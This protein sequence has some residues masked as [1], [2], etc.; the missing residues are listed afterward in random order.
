[1]TMGQGAV[2]SSLS[3]QKLNTQSSCEAELAG[4]DDMATKI[5]WKKFFLKEQGYWIHQNVLYQDNKSK[6]LL[7][8]NG[9]QSAGKQ[10]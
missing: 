10:L 3:K 4:G 7:L 8:K 1:M 6:I 2:Q 9:K 5:L